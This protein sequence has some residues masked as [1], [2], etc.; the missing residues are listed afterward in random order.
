MISLLWI[1]AVVLLLCIS[2][3]GWGYRHQRATLHQLQLHNQLLSEQNRLMNRKMADL[4]EQLTLF[5]QVL[6]ERERQQKGERRDIP[7]RS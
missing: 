7:S 5:S 3:G 4:S 6:D 1:G 2:M